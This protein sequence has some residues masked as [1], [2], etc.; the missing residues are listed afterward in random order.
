MILDFGHTKEI[1][2]D[3]N[4]KDRFS[5]LYNEGEHP[6]SQASPNCIVGLTFSPFSIFGA[7]RL[8][9]RSFAALVYHILLLEI[10]IYI[11]QIRPMIDLQPC[12]TALVS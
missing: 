9:T 10:S 5:T 7:T 1:S 12:I 6:L 8:R 4:V 2:T 3:I 11:L